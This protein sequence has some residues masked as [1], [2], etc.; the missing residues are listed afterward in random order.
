MGELFINHM[1]CQQFVEHSI[2][3]PKSTCHHSGPQEKGGPVITT[4][5]PVVNL[6]T[7]FLTGRT[8]SENLDPSILQKSKTSS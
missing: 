5:P 2:F 1:N 4:E 3:D 7:S 6:K 8:Y